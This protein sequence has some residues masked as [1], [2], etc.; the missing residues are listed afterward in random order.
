[1]ASA[2]ASAPSATSAPAMNSFRRMAISSLVSFTTAFH[3]GDHVTIEL[4]RLAAKLKKTHSRTEGPRSCR[5]IARRYLVGVW[6]A[7]I[8]LLSLGH[9]A[10]S[11]TARTIRIVVPY[12][13]GGAPD[14]VA[15]LLG[16]EIS[17]AHGPTVM[18]ENRPGA[19][20]VIATEAVSRL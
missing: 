15:R 7:I 3:S 5:M 18:I 19:G 10:W 12:A 4:R 13:P 2:P 11:Q 17:R 1:M 20:A 8:L 6:L 9:N 16:D 14:I